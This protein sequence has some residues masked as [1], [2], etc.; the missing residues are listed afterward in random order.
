MEAA[1]NPLPFSVEI[2]SDFKD[3]SILQSDVRAYFE[4]CGDVHDIE[5]ERPA[6]LVVRLGDQA[7][8]ESFQGA[9]GGVLTRP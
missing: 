8:A 7:A 5:I 9:F 2:Q 3:L 1:L 4:L 6:T